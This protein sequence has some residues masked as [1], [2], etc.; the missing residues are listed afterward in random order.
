[1]VAKMTRQ[2][3]CLPIIL[4]QPINTV[5]KDIP[6]TVCITDLHANARIL[7]FTACKSC[8]LCHIYM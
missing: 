8:I 6:C 4:I 5:I 2:D 3:W 1:M 7:Y